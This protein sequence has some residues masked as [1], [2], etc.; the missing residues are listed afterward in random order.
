[1]R[2]EQLT[3]TRFLAAISIVI[4]HY[5]K[6][7]F[8]FN[9]N[10][11]E[12]I[13]RQANIGVSYFFILSGF[14][15][16]I[17]YKNKGKIEF[18]KFIKRRFA[19]VYPVFFLAIIIL[20]IYYTILGKPIDYKG[21]LLN[22]TI[23]Q[24]WVPGKALSFNTPGWSLSVEMFF[25]LCFPFLFNHF[26]KKYTFKKLIFPVLVLFI[27]SQIVLHL[28]RYSSFYDGYP[29]NSHD[30]TFFFP[31][32]HLSEFLIGNLAGLFFIREIK[33]KNYDLQITGLLI[34][35]LILL[36]FNIGIN[37]HNGMMGFLFIPL[38]IL[39]SA[40]NG[41]L[42]KVSNNKFL[43]FLGE[44][45]YSIYILQKPVYTWINGIMKY[46]NIYNAVA[47][48]YTSLIAL[49]LFAAISYKF[50]EIPLRKMINKSN[51]F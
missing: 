47:I 39:I 18:R 48:F 25:Y 50:F 33:V 43:V 46:F 28:L 45:S 22:I 38:I 9:H 6:H 17:A 40:N 32:M 13:F 44:L 19:R 2:I 7:V 29:S 24:S 15:M 16:I 5:A 37:F 42:T 41:Y 27:V 3:F 21:L 30:L 20:L 12:F 51:R 11:V 14:V 10:S 26:Y 35:I 4:Y 1:M 49:L 36:K 34:V 31:L 23:I 8:P